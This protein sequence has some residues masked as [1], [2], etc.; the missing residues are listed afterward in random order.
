M[1]PPKIIHSFWSKPSLQQPFKFGESP[2]ERRFGG[3]VEK[4]YYYMSWALSCLT[5][6]R[7]YQEVELVTD[8]LGKSTLIDKLALPYTNVVIAL[9]KLNNQQKG[10]WA[11]AK[12]HS[13]KLQDKPFLH[14]DSDVFIWKRFDEKIENASL[15][16]QNS[17]VN[18][19]CY[20][21]IWKAIVHNFNHIPDYVLEDFK[22]NKG[23]I[24]ANAGTFGGTDLAFIHDFVDE[25]LLFL[26]NNQTSFEKV[27]IGYSGL[28]YEQYLF[29]CFARKHKKEVSFVFEKMEEDY[30][31]IIDFKKI[32]RGLTYIHVVGDAKKQ[33]EVCIYIEN[34][35]LL[36]YPEYY[37]RIV[38]L[39]ESHEI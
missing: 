32:N 5:L 36:E 17:E 35:L 29:S 23:V 15:V 24:A 38:E 37:Y 3:W 7:F 22:A 12:L 18:F 27:D 2:M 25:A 30:S 11:T 6:R 39:I 21:N 8:S 28:I 19:K 26:E 16:S 14:V 33:M 20:N 4:K 9:D 34:R 10:L 13:Y 1:S 31:S